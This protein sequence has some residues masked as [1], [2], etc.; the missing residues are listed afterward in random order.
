MSPDI[1]LSCLIKGNRPSCTFRIKINTDE[2]VY[3]LKELIND[4]EKIFKNF[5]IDQLV[6]WKMVIPIET[7]KKNQEKYNSVLKNNE[8]TRTEMYADDKIEEYFANSNDAPSKNIHVLI[9][10]RRN[11]DIINKSYEE[12]EKGTTS[13]KSIFGF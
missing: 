7:F 5:D 10:T 9:E 2:D 1:V 12:I 4:Q 11:E 13:D 3:R 6:L 8:R